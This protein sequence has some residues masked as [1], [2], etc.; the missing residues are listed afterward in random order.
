[1]TTLTFTLSEYL[2][3]NGIAFLSG[4]LGSQLALNGLPPKTNGLPTIASLVDPALLTKIHGEYVDAGATILTVDTF[5]LSPWRQ[6]GQLGQ[7]NIS[8]PRITVDGT[9]L[10]EVLASKGI[11]AAYEAADKARAGCGRPVFLAGS[12]TSLNDCYNPDATPP[13][14][15]LLREHFKHVALHARN[16][17]D[18][19]CIETI[20]TLREA[21]AI[22]AA[23][24]A[25]GIPYTIAFTVNDEGNL[26][27]GTTIEEA[28]KETRQPNRIGIGVN[29]CEIG[30]AEIAV[31]KLAKTF[32]AQAV[33]GQHILAYPN[34]YA[35]TRKQWHDHNGSGIEKKHAQCCEAK[36]KVLPADE[37]ANIAAR[38]H[39]KGATI[40]GG[41]CG[42]AP[43]HTKAYKQIPSKSL[44]KQA[45]VA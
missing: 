39:A 22:A 29:C 8:F 4:G 43:A 33:T 35:H 42:T 34:G 37:F 41:C 24:E 14:T 13:E 25:F 40:I 36:K 1:M 16:A 3:Q 26:L 31:E 30:A 32:K 38:L 21:K 23:A 17:P 12:L 45:L 6:D 9:T 19:L 7:G 5:D 10:G 27:D 2:E 15:V 18:L 20:P 11:E 28:E 44:A